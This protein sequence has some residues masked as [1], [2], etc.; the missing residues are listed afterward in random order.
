MVLLATVAF[1]A[2]HLAASADRGPATYIVEPGDTLSDI[3]DRFGTTVDALAALNGLLDPSRIT[4]G[5]VLR[6]RD[7]EQAV[8]PV[9]TF[10]YQVQP[11]DTLSEIALEFGTTAEA[12]AALNGIS[13]TNVIRTGMALGIPTAQMASRS[14]SMVYVVRPGDSLSS[15]AEAYGVTVSSLRQT[16]G[17]LTDV[18]RVGQVMDIPASSLPQLS[19]QTANALQR[20]A[21]ESGVDPYLLMAL[22]L[23]ESGWQNHVVSSAG[24]VGLMQ[25]MPDTAEWTVDYLASGAD[26]WHLSIEDNARVGAA[27]LAHL[28]FIEGGDVDGALASYYQGWA[29]YK[30]YGMYDETRD[31]VDDVL[32]LEAR[33]RAGD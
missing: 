8:H 21:G 25:L 23:M 32:A 6:L 31:Y 9:S 12:I 18:I 24:A 11:G 28:L 20:A 30:Q 7:D 2:P 33:L 14:A 10:S 3:A 15:V 19:A 16:N 1:A 17:L 27:Y 13:E 29:A 4:V 26:N 22:A 5:T